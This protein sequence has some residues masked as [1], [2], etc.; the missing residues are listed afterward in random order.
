M[1]GK[2]ED[3][4]LAELQKSGTA[5]DAVKRIMPH[6]VSN[7]VSTT[8]ISWLI[9]VFTISTLFFFRMN[10]YALCLS[11]GALPSSLSVRLVVGRLGFDSLIE[12]DQ[13]TL[14][15]GIHCF[16]A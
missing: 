2:T 14:K 16:P 12:S 9:F 7:F 11:T 1:I 6:K 8:G 15:V 13:N 3:E 4:V 10:H 5:P